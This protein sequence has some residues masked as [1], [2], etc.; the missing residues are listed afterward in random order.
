MA[1]SLKVPSVGLIFWP[2]GTGDSTTVIVDKKRWVQIDLHHLV[3]AEDDDDDRVPVVDRLL[4]LAPKL[5]GKPYIAAFAATHLDEDH[6]KGFAN[7]LKKAT[8]GEL[9]FSPRVLHSNEDNKDLCADAKVFVKEAQRRINRIA[10]GKTAGSGHR[11]LI[12]GEDDLLSESPYSELPAECFTAPG[13]FFTTLDGEDL[14][15]TFQVFVHSPKKGD[16]DD[17]RNDLS[18]GMQIMISD[19][20]TRGTFLTLG[21]LA[22]PDVKAIFKRG[23]YGELLWSVFQAPHHCSRKVM[24]WQDTDDDEEKRKKDV[25][26]L[27]E[28]HADEDGAWIVASCDSIPSSDKPGDNPPHKAA[29]TAYKAIV[30]SGNF[31]VT[32]DNAPDPRVF[33]FGDDGLELRAPAAKPQPKSP[34]GKRLSEGAA[35]AGGF[36]SSGH[37]SLVGFG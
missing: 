13:E 15:E 17:D 36:S 14:S 19:G 8:I 25:L 5:T 3:A 1:L 29:A 2:V 30:D 23:K 33:E 31:L 7:L 35:A 22:Y 21:D 37:G 16:G 18:L 4:E 11:I 20:D 24:Y 12:I 27:I 9:W 34:Q 32:G 10:D 28:D 26:D 6:I